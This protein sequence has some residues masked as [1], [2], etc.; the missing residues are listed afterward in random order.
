M[1]LTPQP[2][3][4]HEGSPCHYFMEYRAAKSAFPAIR[5]ALQSI[6][7]SRS[8]TVQQVIALGPDLATEL[9]PQAPA[10][11]PFETL[12]EGQQQAV[13][14]Q[15]DIFIW[16]HST[17]VD[18]NI[19]RA[20][21]IHRE[22]SDLATLEVDIP[23][24]AYHDSR[25]LT[26]F[27][28]GSANPK[29]EAAR[30]A[31]LVPES[32]AGAG[33]SFVLTQKWVHDLPQF[34]QLPVHDQEKVVGRTKPDSIEF[35]GDAMPDNS[36]V[37][38]TDAKVDGV[39]QKIYRRSAPFGTVKEHGLFFLAFSC[40]QSRFDVQL[41]RMYGLTEDGIYDRLTDFSKAETSSYWFAPDQS[42]LDSL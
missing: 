35:E 8:E 40:E 17:A 33:G 37:S 31:A 24:F 30:N 13:A 16:L 10:V 6:H 5:Q 29:A 22:L 11:T 27:V 2:G 18:D 25:D 9:L 23:G 21:A 32:N 12:G 26:G 7:Q 1:N 20:L 15:R 3:I 38:R 42:A 19:D 28:D 39:A 41:Q 36:H 34:N 4:F 14:T